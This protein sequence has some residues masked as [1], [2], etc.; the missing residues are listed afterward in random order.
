MLSAFTK[1]LPIILI[2]ALGYLLK[3]T[4]VFEAETGGIFLKLL[5]FVGS[6]ALIYLSV[7]QLTITPS[8]LVFP[9]IATLTMA[10]VYGINSLVA[11]SFSVSRK[12][13]GV[14]LTGT[15][16]ANTAF[17]VPF[18][19]AV[20]GEAAAARVAMYDLA[21]G[22]LTYIFVYALA[23]RHGDQHP[24]PKFIIQ[25]LLISPPLWAL[26][27]ALVVNLAHLPTPEVV[28]AV[29]KN[30][31][32]LV[33]P[34]IMLVLGLYFSPK[35]LHPQLIGWGLITRM[36]GGAMVGLLLSQLFGLTGLDRAVA[37]I[38]AGAPIGF[39]TITFANLEKLDTQFAASL[40]SAAIAVGLISIPILTVILK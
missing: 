7:S 31:A 21:G 5:F 33:S 17:A 28:T 3:K 11:K 36:I 29:L 10:V 1:V 8:L 39:N 4:K 2:F 27:I 38:C 14:Y 15:L 40:V 37:V 35:L 13:L 30:L 20:Y 24:S 26:F 12:T 25:K 22:T 6:P 32:G 16:I 23:V 18:L 34:L 9:I 19:L